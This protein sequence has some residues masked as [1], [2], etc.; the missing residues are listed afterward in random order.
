[1]ILALF[2]TTPLGIQFCD[3]TSIQILIARLMHGSSVV[4]TLLERDLM[5]ILLVLD[6][7]TTRFESG[8]SESGPGDPFSNTI[9]FLT[10][11]PFWAILT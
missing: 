1:M 6:P 8:S 11:F 10:P 9:G 4:T 2:S 5:G 3:D 7:S